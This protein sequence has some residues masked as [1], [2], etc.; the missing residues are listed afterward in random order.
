MRRA[1]GGRRAGK[2]EREEVMQ[3]LL[4][5]SS[6][7]LLSLPKVMACRK[8]PEASRSTR[9]RGL[10]DGSTLHEAI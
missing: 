7:L 8:G 3:I 6:L 10:H 9:R 2:E 4:L 5:L 1:G